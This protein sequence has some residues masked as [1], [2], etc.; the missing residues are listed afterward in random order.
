MGHCCPLIIEIEKY[1]RCAG[2]R[3]GPTN[4]VRRVNFFTYLVKLLDM[5]G[6]TIISVEHLE[7]YKTIILFGM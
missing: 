2:G 5:F 4:V 7:S 6:K 3:R 1:Y